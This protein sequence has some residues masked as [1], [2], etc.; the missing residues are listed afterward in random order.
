MEEHMEHVEEDIHET[1][2]GQM[3]QVV[4]MDSHHREHAQAIQKLLHRLIQVE[5]HL[6]TMVFEAQVWKEVESNQSTTDSTGPG[7]SLRK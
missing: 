3:Q 4:A 1:R 5:I 7:T 2:V 6:G